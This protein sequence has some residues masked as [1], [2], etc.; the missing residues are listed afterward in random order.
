MVAKRSN[1]NFAFNIVSSSA[2]S[3]EELLAKLR[4]KYDRS[5]P[6]HCP[7]CG[8]AV[9]VEDHPGGYPLPWSCPV[10][11]EAL[12]ATQA[13]E[14]SQA[15]KQEALTHWQASRWEDYRRVGDRRVM[16]LIERYERL[17]DAARQNQPSPGL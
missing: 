8:T 9:T 15:Q 16:E 7:T 13:P 1:I 4:A 5:I 14:V 17:L 12:R 2:L 10:A 6:G 11:Q 3:D